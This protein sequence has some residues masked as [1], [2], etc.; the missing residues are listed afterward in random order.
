MGA[1][2]F[3]PLRPRFHPPLPDAAAGWEWCSV[4]PEPEREIHAV[5][6]PNRSHAVDSLRVAFGILESKRADNNSLLLFNMIV[7]GDV[8][9]SAEWAYSWLN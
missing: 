1:R 4:S 8:P 2:G 3:S 6:S 7:A 5:C 9:V